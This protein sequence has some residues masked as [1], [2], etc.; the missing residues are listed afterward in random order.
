MLAVGLQGR[1]EIANKGPLPP[2]KSIAAGPP[3]A[4]KMRNEVEK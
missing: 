4:G 3:Q 2:S 1:V